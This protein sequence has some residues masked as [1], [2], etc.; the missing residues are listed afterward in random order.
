M[1]VWMTK[2]F[3]QKEHKCLRGNVE[4]DHA[5]FV[6]W[7]PDSKV[8]REKKKS[9][10][11]FNLKNSNVQAYVVQKA[12]QNCVEVYKINKKPDGGLGNIGMAVSF[13]S[14]HETDIIGMGMAATGR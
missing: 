7:S 8:G 11:L 3:T 5:L 12:V 6:K 10:K 13:P 2:D 1:L 4:Y 14:L 9:R